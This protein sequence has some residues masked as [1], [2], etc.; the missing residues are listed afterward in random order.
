MP[1]GARKQTSNEM[2]NEADQPNDSLGPS[3]VAQMSHADMRW[4]AAFSSASSGASS[5]A[6]GWQASEVVNVQNMSSNEADVAQTSDPDESACPGTPPVQ[7]DDTEDM[8]VEDEI[9]VDEVQ[10]EGVRGNEVS[11]NAGEAAADPPAA[12]VVPDADAVDETVAIDG[13]PNAEDA[14]PDIDDNERAGTTQLSM[15]DGSMEEA[16]DSSY[17]PSSQEGL[18]HSPEHSASL[19]AES[20][21]DSAPATKP[22]KR[23]AAPRA[24]QSSSAAAASAPRTKAKSRIVVSESEV[25]HRCSGVARPIIA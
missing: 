1:M 6:L 15:G 24:P 20:A 11:E 21:L 10:G 12:D 5:G 14:I 8:D 17:V 4:A 18:S 13:P 25:C 19:E 2:T 22:R 16:P 23:F 3:Q 7:R 9:A